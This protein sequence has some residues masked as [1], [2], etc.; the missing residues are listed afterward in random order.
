MSLFM[1]IVITLNILFIIFIVLVL[2]GVIPS[3]WFEMSGNEG[4]RVY[5]YNGPGSPHLTQNNKFSV[6]E[7]YAPMPR[8]IIPDY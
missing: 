1:I 3:D 7:G 5:G 8:P 2:S 4:Y 6:G